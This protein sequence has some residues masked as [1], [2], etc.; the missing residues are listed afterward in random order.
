MKR[1]NN[2]E[3]QLQPGESRFVPNDDG[4]GNLERAVHDHEISEC[5]RLAML[6]EQQDGN[7][8]PS[9][10]N[11][12]EK[13]ARLAERRV[14]NT[15]RAAFREP[16]VVISVV[17]LCLLFF[18][19]RPFLVP[20][21]SMIPTL[22]EGDRILSLAQYFPNGR[23]YDRGD[24]VC[25][26]APSG[27]VY[28]KRVIGV[29]GDRIQ[30]SGEKVYVN[31]E[32]SPWQGTGG[33]QSSMDV[34]LDDNQYWVMGD[35]RGNSEDSRFIGPISADKMISKVYLIYWPLSDFKVF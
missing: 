4:F 6:S 1:S 20:S 29:G 7:D 28:V 2:D 34:Q 15:I 16:V 25:F 33:V 18:F 14:I 3:P 35:N 11:D 32:L 31:G 5:E 12:D 17:L 24:I 9:G 8:S 30:I 27:D 21:G 13:A 19:L 10:E 23:T 22:K 26:T